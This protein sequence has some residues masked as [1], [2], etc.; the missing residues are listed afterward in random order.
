MQLVQTMFILWEF[1][2]YTDLQTFSKVTFVWKKPVTMLISH[3]P[4]ILNSILDIMQNIKPAYDFM[5][6][7]LFSILSLLQS[8]LIPYT[9][10]FICIWAE[11]KNILSLTK[12]L[13]L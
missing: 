1:N 12:N 9:H 3:L 13:G 6:F 7:I 5:D 11:E 10:L 2:L 8:L 4:Q